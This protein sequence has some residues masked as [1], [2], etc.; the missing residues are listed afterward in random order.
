MKVSLNPGTESGSRPHQGSNDEFPLLTKAQL[1]LRPSRHVNH[2][3]ER[4]RLSS[5][6]SLTS[7]ER[8]FILVLGAG[9]TIQPLTHCRLCGKTL[10]S[11]ARVDNAVHH[12][13]CTRCGNVSIHEGVD[14][15]PIRDV[16]HLLSG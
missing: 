1:Y 4:S 9:M 3:G 7:P 14:P 8:G 15:D 13:A 12:Y 2:R 10:E 5:V 6:P 11:P 16:I